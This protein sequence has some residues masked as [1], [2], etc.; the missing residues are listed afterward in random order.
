MEG[1]GKIPPPLPTS[2]VML[3]IWYV[4]THSCSF[5]KHT[6]QYHGPLNFAVVSIFANNQHFLAKM[7]PLLKA[8]VWQI[9]Y[10]FLVL[11]SA[12]ARLKITFNE[13]LSFTEYASGIRL[14]G[15]SKLVTNQKND[16][17]VKT[18]RHDVI[19]NFL[20]LFCFSCQV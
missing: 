7:V 4:S 3:E 12:F 11:F 5:R 10:K 6:F 1:G 9:C 19:I 8:I 17:D 2:R 15:C 18:C 16:N 13:N 14:L 20:T